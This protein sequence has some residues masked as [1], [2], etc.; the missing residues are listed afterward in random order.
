MLSAE[1]RFGTFLLPA[2][3]ASSLRHSFTENRHCQYSYHGLEFFELQTDEAALTRIRGLGLW[4]SGVGG[5]R[6]GFELD[7][8]YGFLKA[9]IL[10]M[11]S[12]LCH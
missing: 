12:E 10:I 7:G 11:P 1:S 5:V 8:N 3:F 9:S 6:G 4:L 2:Q